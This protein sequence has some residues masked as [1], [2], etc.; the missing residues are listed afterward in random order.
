MQFARTRFKYH[1]PL[2]CEDIF[3]RERA[4]PLSLLRNVTRES[5]A[6]TAIPEDPILKPARRSSTKTGFKTT[7]LLVRD[8]PGNR[9]GRSLCRCAQTGSQKKLRSASSNVFFQPKNISAIT[10]ARDPLAIVSK[11]LT[12][13]RRPQRNPGFALMLAMKNCVSWLC[14]SDFS[15]LFKRENASQYRM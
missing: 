7:I 15:H 1:F 10:I 14:F 13:R 9:P 2:T 8:Q 3:V 12:Q 4:P 6:K 5:C 11:E